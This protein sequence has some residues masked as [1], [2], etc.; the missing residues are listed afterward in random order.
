MDYQVSD[1]KK[2]WIGQ[3]TARQRP[4]GLPAVWWNGL[5]KREKM[6]IEWD[7]ND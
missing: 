7:F 2:C 5:D 3:K 6:L 4:K 1:G